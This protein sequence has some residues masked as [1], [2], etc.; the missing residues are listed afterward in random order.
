MLRSA[1]TKQ[2]ARQPLGMAG[3]ERRAV[4]TCAYDFSSSLWRMP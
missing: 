1:C 3:A 4:A 2:S